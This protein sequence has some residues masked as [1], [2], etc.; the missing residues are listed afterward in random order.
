MLFFDVQVIALDFIQCVLT[1]LFIGQTL[2]RGTRRDKYMNKYLQIE[3]KIHNNS[4]KDHEICL[5]NLSYYN[6]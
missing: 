5:K 2:D 4:N 1:N 3:S 6:N